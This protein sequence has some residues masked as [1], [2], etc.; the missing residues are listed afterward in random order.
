MYWGDTAMSTKVSFFESKDPTR[1][2][3]VDALLEEYSG[4]E[5]HLL[6]M[7]SKEYQ[8]K[9]LKTQQLRIDADAAI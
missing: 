8:K 7:L 6:V 4:K 3:A 1:I 2:V 5:D 9:D